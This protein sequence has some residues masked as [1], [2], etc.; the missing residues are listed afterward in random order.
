[1][2]KKHQKQLP[3]SAVNSDHAQVK[4]L[5]VISSIIDNNPTLAERILQDLNRGKIFKS[6]GGAK[7]TGADQVL[8]ASIVMILFGFTYKGCSTKLIPRQTSL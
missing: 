3:L 4:E 7:G 2:R 8:R 5:D 6:K 1:M